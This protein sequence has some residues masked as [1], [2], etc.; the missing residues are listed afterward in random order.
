MNIQFK[1]PFHELAYSLEEKY[2][3]LSGKPI[4]NLVLSLSDDLDFTE[5][6]N[7]H[8]VHKA[9]SFPA[10]FPPQLPNKFIL[11]LT[12]PGDIVLDP[13]MGS[14]TTI[15]ETYLYGRQAV[16]FDIDPLAILLTQMK[17][18]PFSESNLLIEGNRILKEAGKVV[19]LY[20]NILLSEKERR[21]DEKTIEFID[22]WFAEEVQKELLALLVEIEKIE[23]SEI[24]NFLKL[25]FSSIII[26][27][28]GGVSLALDLAHTRPHKAK[29]VFAKNGKVLFGD[30]AEDRKHLIK[31]LRSPLEEFRKKLD[32][33][34]RY[35]I[36]AAPTKLTP[37]LNFGS[38]Q[39][40]S[41]SSNSVDL[42]VTSP[43]YAS[44]AIDYMRAHKF[45]LIWFG[46]PIAAL[47][48]KRKTYIGSEGFAD[49]PSVKLPENV[50]NIVVKIGKKSNSKGVSLRRYYVEMT[51]VIKEMYRVLKPEKS[52][53][54][55]VGNS[56][57]AGF[58]AQVNNSL[59][60]IGK[61]I[62]FQVPQVGIRHLD[63]NR[64][65][66]PASSTID[67][68][69]QIQQRMHEE[70]VIGFYKS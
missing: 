42:I 8:L 12:D 54:V 51:L 36:T 25:V 39:S 10:K 56:T 33:V 46:Y 14:G 18:Q 19:R 52:A 64:R 26:T 44:N 16:G 20:P 58:D 15:V 24:K 27:K 53:I 65:M 38:A 34:V 45:S 49:L 41:L 30:E 22:Y 2:S 62:G 17:V 69:S 35:V 37:I 21:F 32:Q 4:E 1:L 66:M 7:T 63:R 60:E 3:R 59:I 6:N 31:S 5:N 68:S 23:S 47:T 29:T 11:E 48:E 55:V 28:T 67:K 9:H 70:F 57:L 50:E 43:P 61:E 13:M 40:L